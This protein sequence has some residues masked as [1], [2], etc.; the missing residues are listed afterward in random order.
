[1]DG[2]RFDEV[3]KAAG[4]GTGGT[5]LK[6]LAGGALAVLLGRATS[7]QASAAVCRPN[8]RVCRLDR[9]CCSGECRRDRCIR[10]RPG[11]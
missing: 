1:M 7:Q 10:D 11:H 6:V 3:A 5:A 8:G 2:R 4:T 9:Q